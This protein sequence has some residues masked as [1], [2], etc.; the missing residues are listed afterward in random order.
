MPGTMNSRKTVC[1]SV[2]ASAGCFA[3]V[4]ATR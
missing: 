2:S 3:C 4:V 1:V